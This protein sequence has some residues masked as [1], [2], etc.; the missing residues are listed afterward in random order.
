MLQDMGDSVFVADVPG[1]LASTRPSLS[2]EASAIYDNADN[3][4]SYVNNAS[5]A[6]ANH[7]GMSEILT[8][9]EQLED[10]HGFDCPCDECKEV[11]GAE[12]VRVGHLPGDDAPAIPLPQ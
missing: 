12:Y 7:D 10:G 6:H 5:D 11:Y 1:S 8:P 3:V 2:P 4:A 9:S